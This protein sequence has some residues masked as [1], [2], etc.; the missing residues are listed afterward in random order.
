MVYIYV[1]KCLCDKYYIGKTNNPQ[2]R[3]N[4]HYYGNGSQWTNIYKPIEMVEIIPD[5]DKYDE[6]KYTI[7]YMDIYGIDNV[8]GGSWSKITFN[9]QEKECLRKMLRSVNDKCYKCGGDG[10]YQRDCYFQRD[11]NSQYSYSYTNPTYNN[12]NNVI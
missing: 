7:K 1:L 5:C 4:N 10:H 6:D 9:N 11:I 3:I 8:R 2:F 12:Q